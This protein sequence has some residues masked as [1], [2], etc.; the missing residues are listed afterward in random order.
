MTLRENNLKELEGATIFKSQC[1]LVGSRR[2]LLER[3]GLI[4][5]AHELIER[6]EVSLMNMTSHDESCMLCWQPATGNFI[7][8]MR[9]DQLAHEPTECLKAGFPAPSG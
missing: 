8:M 4:K 2:A 6:L 5:V 7:R 1:V 9:L 3:P